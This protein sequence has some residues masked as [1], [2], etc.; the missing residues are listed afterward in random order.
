[1]CWF[2]ACPDR[3]MPPDLALR[4]RSRG[5][6]VVWTHAQMVLAMA[7][8]TSLAT[9]GTCALSAV[10]RM[11]RLNGLRGLADVEAALCGVHVIRMGR[12]LRSLRFF[13]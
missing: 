6:R 2:V 13:G 8:G 12:G 4:L 9:T 7:A 11:E 1:M 10:D 5:R 3:M